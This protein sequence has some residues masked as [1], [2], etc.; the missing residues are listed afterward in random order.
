[1]S[2]EENKALVRH[3]L[4]TLFRGDFTPFDEH[5][6]LAEI[7]QTLTQAAA[8]M[9][10]NPPTASIEQLI[11]EGEWVAARSVFRGGIF[12]ETGFEALGFYQVVDGKIVKQY[13]QDGP[14]GVRDAAGL[15]P[16]SGT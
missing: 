13:S 4:E 12:G 1:M 15:V 5:P 2:A 3:V 6:G 10:D 11:A 8:M 9:R 16:P 14:M 7:K